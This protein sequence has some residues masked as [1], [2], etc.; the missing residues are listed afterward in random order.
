MYAF[1][2]RVYNHISHDILSKNGPKSVLKTFYTFTFESVKEAINDIIEFVETKLIP[3]SKYDD[4]SN[5]NNNLVG[6]DY[7]KLFEGLINK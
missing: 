4:Y 2:Y 5:V 6:I 3:L 1:G 7:E